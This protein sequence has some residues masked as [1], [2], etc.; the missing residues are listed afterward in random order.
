MEDKTILA[1]AAAVLLVVLSKLKS[2]F[3]AKPKLN[4]PPGP[5]RLP[6][7]GHIHHLGTCP[8]IY[9]T[10]GRLAQKHGPLMLFH[11]GEIPFLVA[12]SPEAA[13]A[14]M[15][16]HDT[17]FADR[18]ATTTL[19]TFTFGKTDLAFGPYGE[20]WRQL[21]KMCVLELLSA[22]RVQSFRAIREEET[23]RLVGNVAARAGAAVD[24]S[25]EVA[26]FI[27]DTFARECVG[28][29]CKYQ[30]EWLH[31]FH[32]AVQLTSGLTLS[33]LFPS[34]RLL[35]MLGSAPRKARVC[36]DRITRVLDL[37]IQ[38]KA[39]ALERGEKPGH[40]TIL[41]VLLRLQKEGN[42]PVPLT[43]ETL[44]ALMFNLF[45]A[46]SDTSS[47]TMNWCMTELI[48]SPAVMAK[49]QAEVREAF[50]GK[51][52]LTEEDIAGADLSYLRL[53]I[54][55]TLRLHPPV[56]LLL[57]R[58]TRETCQPMGYDVPK[59]TAVFV[60]VWAIGRDPKYWDDPEEFKPERFQNSNTDYKGNNFE[61]L[62]FG[63]GRRMC[64]G[65]N[66]GLANLDL[67]LTSLLYHFDWKLPNGMEPK[68]V[69]VWE[70]M[71][72]IANKRNN[73]I[74]HPITRIAPTNA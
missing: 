31:A 14:V 9:R 3:A 69:D 57:P 42:M 50:K 51:N 64:P 17:S 13:Q 8:L 37:I 71:G 46:G 11:L 65:I 16:T 22:A 54:K 25:K 4:L 38:E 7:I 43:N 21:R 27:V 26:G 60:N 28:S 52:L 6:V 55:E 74:L 53:V 48:R 56:P 49:V 20:R 10:L 61:F 36:L 73:L 58:Q 32:E 45:G 59:G 66:L 68:D 12:S 41:G 24:V 62:P 44:V 63:A 33:D 35:R 34:S 40:E 5:S 23:A 47:I 29:R 39:E 1:V 15:K 30:D 2:L 70:S 19:N 18:F 67:A 72:L